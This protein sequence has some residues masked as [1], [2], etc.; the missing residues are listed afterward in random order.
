[1]C[2]SIADV[3]DEARGTLVVQKTEADWLR[4]SILVLGFSNVLGY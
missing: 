1:M 2:C 3:D 4:Y